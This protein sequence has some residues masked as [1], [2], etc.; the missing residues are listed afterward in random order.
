MFSGFSKLTAD[1]INWV[2]VANTNNQI[3]FIDTNS[4]KYSKRDLLSVIVK[5]SEI[6]PVDQTII[7]TQSYMMAVD[8]ENRLF[9][10]LPV[11]GEI[12]QVKNWEEPINNKLIKTTII[13]S[14]AY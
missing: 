3:Q 9:S 6:N 2:K 11:N 8:C 12:K 10:K 4:I 1:E 14:C 5:S 13:N 7:S